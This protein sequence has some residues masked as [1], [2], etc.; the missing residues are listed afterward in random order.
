MRE[1]LSVGVVS[2][3][4][5]GKESDYAA[6]ARDLRERCLRV[7]NHKRLP[8]RGQLLLATADWCSPS[9]SLSRYIR[10]EFE[11]ELG[12][13]VPLIGASM[14]GVFC[15]TDPKPFIQEGLALIAVCS[16]DFRMTVGSLPQPYGDTEK[17]RL[18]RLREMADQLQDRARPRLG[19]GAQR[20]LL[21]FLPG[22]FL[23]EAGQQVYFDNELHGE[24]LE[25]FRYR[26][27]LYGGAAADSITPTKGYQFADDECLESGLALAIIESDLSTGGAVGHGF[28]PIR[29]TPFSVDHLVN[30]VKSGYDVALLDGVPAE[31][32][33]RDLANE[34]I[35]GH[36]QIV[37]GIR[38]GPD[39]DVFVP[40]NIY[41]GEGGSIRLNR[42]VSQGDRIYLL[43]A[44]ADQMVEADV[45]L[46]RRAWKNA[47]CSE[48]VD[49]GLILAFSCVGRFDLCSR[50][51]LPWQ[52]VVERVRK[53]YPGVPLLAGL[54]AGEFGVDFWHRPR[55]N[56]MSV[57]LCCLT[58]RLREGA[59]TRG[60]QE[61]LLAV[62][63]AVST[64]TT[65]QEVMKLALEGAVEAGA[66]G[67]QICVV[68]WS[69]RRIVGKHLG[70][71]YQASGSKHNWLSVLELTDRDAPVGSGP[72]CGGLPP[73][74][75]EW[76]VWLK[77]PVADLD[78][79]SLPEREDVLAL[80]VRCGVALFVA[81]ARDPRFICEQTAVDACVGPP[82]NTLVF[83]AVPL[84]GS[85]GKAIGTMQVSFPDETVLDREST[86]LW[87]GYGQKVA[88]ALERAQEA[89]EL[90]IRNAISAEA[91]W[92]SAQPVNTKL[93]WHEW[94]QEICL[95]FVKT[96]RR[97]LQASGTHMR[98]RY[99]SLTGDEFSLVAGDG[100]LDMLRGITRPII[101][102]G[103]GSL[104]LHVLG[105]EGR[106]TNTKEQTK[107]LN[108]GVTP[109][110]GDT[111]Y[112]MA[113]VRERD[114]IEC[115]AMLPI[116]DEHKELLGS[117]VIDS[118]QQHFFVERRA[119][120]ARF[121]ADVAGTMVRDR[122]T[123]YD[124]AM[125]R[126]EQDR[127]VDTLAATTGSEADSSLRRIIECLC[128]ATGAD[129]GSIYLWYESAGKLV[130][131]I[132]H[133][134]HC[135]QELEGKAFYR[136]GEGWTGSVGLV[137]DLRES[138][139]IVDPIKGSV[140]KCTGR[141][142]DSMVAEEHQ[143]P[144]GKGDARIGLRLAIDKDLIGVVTLAYWRENAGILVRDE[145]RIRKFSKALTPLVTLAAE[146]A[147]QETVRREIAELIKAE[148]ATAEIVIQAA[149][150]DGDWQ[151]VV[152]AIR[153][154]FRVERVTL[155]HFDGQRLLQHRTSVGRGAIFTPFFEGPIEPTGPMREVVFGKSDVLI[156]PD[157]S[158]LF[159]Q[160]PTL[161][162]ASGAFLV[163]VLCTVGDMKGVLEFINRIP[164]RDHPFEMFDEHEQAVARDAARIV[165]AGL[166]H[167]NHE[168]Q[169]GELRIQATTAMRIGAASI[170]SA[171]V[172]HQIMAPFARIQQAV[173]WLR[174]NPGE[175][176]CDRSIRLDRIQAACTEAVKIVNQAAGSGLVLARRESLRTIVGQA[177]R[178]VK[179]DIPVVGVNVEI[180]NTV[181]AP[182]FAD[183]V[184][185][186]GALV[187]LLSNAID[188]IGKS[189]VLRVE[190]ELD[191][192]AKEG[193]IR[194]RNTGFPVEPQQISQ[195][196][197]PG[198]TC[199][200]EEGH[201]GIG[202]KVAQQAI[203]MA[204]GAMK[205]TPCPEGGVEVVVTLP[206]YDK[207]EVRR[208]VTGK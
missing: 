158:H 177:M 43:R 196:F 182:V 36:G 26:H 35:E 185:I 186:V 183:V 44:S 199:K 42:R 126:E 132:A 142:Y 192:D 96:V 190:T 150:P 88:T 28:V 98:I 100:D 17:H 166:D 131:R 180:R 197:L 138:V 194:I 39:F 37:F 4:G 111:S 195:F 148:Q 119:R 92:I 202:L 15:S 68:D 189:G 63:S 114:K 54:C 130:L 11:R 201:L 139:Q 101:K 41:R 64:G 169:E 135:R 51:N 65:P 179:P 40:L 95:P 208:R 32:R 125:L 164:D 59:R 24:I 89:E 50:Q 110:E 207:G 48:F 74:L 13:S 118:Q 93:E 30:G 87:A 97:E 117:F 108:E 9:N 56:N 80:V 165:G 14:A 33:L 191:R 84:I 116:Y 45:A 124:H 60:L 82:P 149:R 187:N 147:E 61:S 62:A 104:K 47:N 115:T 69:L 58:S 2:H 171:I 94:C 188:A 161:G 163:P 12:Y 156:G 178:V 102:A 83:L 167:R 46:L 176:D 57:S 70:C 144:K 113:F 193:I 78:T 112:Q 79:C 159:S 73:T 137:D 168:I 109:L 106:I 205:M 174:L 55:A 128:N 133:N 16:D 134:W 155:Y 6:V 22:V 206:I 136:L 181:D 76:A 143:V 5:P 25:V 184:S 52:S 198:Y 203:Q 18:Q 81:D 170:T 105:K 154:K 162:N 10:Q 99:Q 204:G 66:Q 23:D 72:C 20:D 21:G 140:P 146:V 90:A 160:W 8:V 122:R 152:D 153:E 1:R 120:I 7:T 129:V 31:E 151:A 27:R 67:G 107:M 53:D 173:E 145:E 49:L 157:N 127:I 75:K 141:Y 86:R 3:H 77:P 34:Q 123:A 175:S 91:S 121:V 19:M 200:S 71:A 38:C 172:M 85:D 29:D 103:D